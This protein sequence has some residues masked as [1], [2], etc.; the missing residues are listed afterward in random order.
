MS[1]SAVLTS[2]FVVIWAF[3]SKLIMSPFFNWAFFSLIISALFFMSS[4]I[5]ISV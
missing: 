4:L 3:V 5:F 2:A 1:E